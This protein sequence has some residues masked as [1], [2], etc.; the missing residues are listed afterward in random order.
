MKFFLIVAAS[1]CIVLFSLFPLAFGQHTNS[2]I[3]HNMTT[4][5]GLASNTVND[6]LELPS[7]YMLFGTSNGLNIYDGYSMQLFKDGQKSKLLPSHIITALVLDD[8]DNIWTG[9]SDGIIRLSPNGHIRD[10]YSEDRDA[11]Y[12]IPNDY[13]FELYKDS[14]GHIWSG[15]AHGL[16]RYDPE[17]DV[18]KEIFIPGPDSTEQNRNRIWDICEDQNGFVWLATD[19]GLYKLYPENEKIESYHHNPD[20][21]HSLSSNSVRSVTVD[22]SNNLWIGTKSGLNYFDTQKTIFKCYYADDP[23][24]NTLTHDHIDKVFIDRDGNLWLGTQ[25]GINRFV[26]EKEKF[27]QFVPDRTD[28]QSLQGNNIVDIFQDQGGTL[29]FASFHSGVSKHV[30]L[31]ERFS[32]SSPNKKFLLQEFPNREFLTICH[33]KDE[34]YWAGSYSGL[35]L[36]DRETDSFEFVESAAHGPYPIQ[37]DNVRVLYKDSK[38][39]LWM[40]SYLD[41][42]SGLTKYNPKSNKVIFYSPEHP[43]NK[44][45]YHKITSI[46]EDEEGYIWL[47]TEGKGLIRLNPETDNYEWIRADYT[48]TTNTRLSGDW[49]YQLYK[50]SNGRIWIGTD[51][52]VNQYHPDKEIFISYTSDPED[53]TTLSDERI[54]CV[55][56]DDSDRIW[57]GTEKGLN[58]FDPKNKEFTNYFVS[59]GMASDQIHAIQQDS[60][61]FLWFSTARGLTRF[62]P[63]NALFLNFDYSDGIKV[64]DFNN[65]VSVVAKNGDLIF[66]GLEGFVHFNPSEFEKPVNDRPV[67]LS[68]FK[69]F[70]KTLYSGLELASI[71]TIQLNY[72]NNSIQFEFALLNY[73]KPEHNRYAYR[74]EGFDKEWIYSRN[75]RYAGYTNMAPGSYN[76][77]VKAANNHGVWSDSTL[78]VHVQIVAPFWQKTEFVVFTVGSIVL[79]ILIGYQLRMKRLNRRRMELETLVHQRTDEIKQKSKELERSKERYRLLYDHA[80]VSYMELDDSGTILDLNETNTEMLGYSLPEMHKH[81]YFEFVKPEERDEAK[82]NLNRILDTNEI[83]NIERTLICKNGKERLFNIYFR[84]VWNEL[85]GKR[86]V[87]LALQDVTELQQL[88][89]QLRQ[90][91]KMEAIG[92]LAGG[93]AHDFNNIL[94]IIRGYCALLLGKLKE[95]SLIQ[96]VEHI[97]KASER[98]ETLTRQLLAFSRKQQLQPRSVNIN[99]LIKNVKTLL[100][101]LLGEEIKL[102]VECPEEPGWIHVDPNQFENAIMNLATNAK[103]AMPNGGSLNLEVKY[104]SFNQAYISEKMSLDPGDYIS[105]AVR[106]TGEGMGRDTLD[107]LFEPFYTT[108]PKGK[109]TGLGLAMVYGFVK[110]SNGNLEVHSTKGQ[111]TTFFLYFPRIDKTEKEETSIDTLAQDLHGRETILVVE[112]EKNVRDL[113]TFI[114]QEQ[115]Y[116]VLDSSDDPEQISSVL[117]RDGGIDLILS[118]VMMPNQNGPQVVKKVKQVFPDIKVIYMSAY[119]DDIL[120]NHGLPADEIEFI[121]KPF[122]PISLASKVRTVLDKNE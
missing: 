47:G 100:V 113:V 72:Q 43:Q 121:K 37:G 109:G 26:P 120:T 87:H 8:K 50:D 7:G 106:D 38:G 98:A 10:R 99:L 48:D 53:S 44:I 119:S 108:K 74:L 2:A 56:Q 69:T 29:W 112:D 63:N 114:L 107:H 18:I 22:S 11:P 36:W 82:G 1:F 77:Y 67:V 64:S 101:P 58:K 20:N 40:G 57:I 117:Q 75:R 84:V 4:E 46:V 42:R 21:P 94:T 86:T 55:Y 118:D 103:D 35:F 93:V 31:S 71:D 14:Q 70:Y 83:G 33:H 16:A 12:R 24:N 25:W 61:G 59:D 5:D 28:P 102:D 62:N 51:H 66:G 39:H 45:P 110:Q 15:T 73:D 60:D 17:M 80:P 115:G 13:V 52:G 95:N 88:E 6:V 81:S 23:E 90:T 3:F 122:T 65:N 105:V 89:E 92:R 9:T 54:N 41:E 78:S 32:Y 34:K 68:S 91:Q 27:D 49:I 96:R 97:D 116:R 30:A 76:F 79:F 111:G 85:I 19:N 104:L